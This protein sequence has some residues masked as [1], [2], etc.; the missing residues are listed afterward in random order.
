MA[1]DVSVVKDRR[2]LKRFVTFPIGLLGGNPNYVPPL[3]SDD[4]SILSPQKNPAFE[5]SEARQFL[6]RRDGR[7][8]GRVAAILN[9]PANLKYGTKNLRFGWFD[10]VDDP[11]VFAAL[12]AAVEA[13]GRERGMETLTG[14]QGFT[15]LDPE[16]MLVEGFDELA[17]IAEVW[18]P[19]YYPAGLERL[20]FIKEVDYIEFEARAPAGGIPERMQRLAEF[21]LKRNKFRIARYRTAREIARARAKELFDLL[22]EAY[23]ELYASTPLTDRQKWYYAK[24]YLPFINPDLVKV[25]VD[26]NDR[27]IGFLISMPSLSRALQRARG[28]LF[29]FGFLHILRALKRFERLDFYLAGVKKEHRNKGVDLVMVVDVFRDALRYGIKVAESNPELETNRKIQAEWKFVETRQHKRRRIYR[30]AIAP[31]P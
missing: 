19:P 3:V 26:E 25:A 10:A 5:N 27:M 17:T 13:W 30:K 21:A 15:D 24:K 9:H 11:E 20:G 1:I 4:M 28:R 29:P 6:A 31:A 7:I 2:D 18:N 8:V 23:A 22:D 14:P 16:G 12:F